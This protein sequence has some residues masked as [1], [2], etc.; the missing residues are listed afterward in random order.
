[1]VVGRGMRAD[2]CRRGEQSRDGADVAL[3]DERGSTGATSYRT[4]AKSTR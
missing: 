3:A 1:M 2:A 4:P